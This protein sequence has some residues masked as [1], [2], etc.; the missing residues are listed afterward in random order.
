MPGRY[1]ADTRV[2]T[3]KSRMEIERTLVRYGC[4]ECVSGWNPDGAFFQFMFKGRSVMMR[5]PYTIA[6]GQPERQVDQA[7]R[8]RWRVLLLLVKANLEAVECGLVPFE[9]AFLPWMLLQDGQTVA[10]RMVPQL[11]PVKDVPKLRE[12]NR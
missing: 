3:D 9:V 12:V 1:A 10:E 6:R 8:Q 2:T 4:I 7:K 5:V 11:P